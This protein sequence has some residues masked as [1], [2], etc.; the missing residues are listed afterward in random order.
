MESTEIFQLELSLTFIRC[1][2]DSIHM[3]SVP[4]LRQGIVHLSLLLAG[5]ESPEN[6]AEGQIW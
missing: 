6:Q 1:P 3:C 4:V 5:H 2:P